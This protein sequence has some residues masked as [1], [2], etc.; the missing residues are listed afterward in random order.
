MPTAPQ[1]LCR[2]PLVD[3]HTCQTPTLCGYTAC[4]HTFRYCLLA[5]YQGS[6]EDRQASPRLRLTSLLF[7]RQTLCPQFMF[8]HFA[9]TFAGTASGRSTRATKRTARHPPGAQ[10]WAAQGQ[11][12]AEGAAAA[13]EEA[14]AGATRGEVIAGSE[15]VG[16][17][18]WTGRGAP[19]PPA[20]AE[21]SGG[22]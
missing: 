21:G 6:E 18:T 4:A 3:L 13:V 8:P 5:Q 19:A 17:E 15:G 16:G 1:T 14:A 11:A 9:F 7:C 12:Q 22:A 20:G 10:R 2:L